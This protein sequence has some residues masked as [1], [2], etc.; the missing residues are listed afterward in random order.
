MK[1]IYDLFITDEQA[2]NNRKR[3]AQCL[4]INKQNCLALRQNNIK[5]LIKFESKLGFNFTDASLRP[6]V[7]DIA[8]ALVKTKIEGNGDRSTALSQAYNGL[9]TIGNLG[10]IFIDLKVKGREMRV[11]LIEGKG[12]R[13]ENIFYIEPTM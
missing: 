10:S 2:A 13:F 7:T 9:W 12:S 11:H 6:I 8:E 1:N 4:S 3:L 5:K